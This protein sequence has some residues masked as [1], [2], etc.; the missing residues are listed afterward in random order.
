MP[1]IARKQPVPFD[2]GTTYPK[3]AG[4]RP[5]SSLF[6]IIDTDTGEPLLDDQGQP[7]DTGGYTDRDTAQAQAERYNRTSA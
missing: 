5:G 2:H 4:L 3:H 7:V 1:I 6:R